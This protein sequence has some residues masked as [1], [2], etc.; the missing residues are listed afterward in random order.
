MTFF[1]NI[2]SP[3]RLGWENHGSD[4]TQYIPEPHSGPGMLRLSY[5][6]WVII[7]RNASYLSL[8]PSVAGTA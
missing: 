4:H 3:E 6:L 1:Q 8:L 5:N 2:C 7:I